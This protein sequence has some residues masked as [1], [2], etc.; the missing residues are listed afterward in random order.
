MERFLQYLTNKEVYLL[1]PTENS[2][3]LANKQS[4][5][6][7]SLPPGDRRTPPTPSAPSR[8]DFGGT[9]SQNRKAST[10]GQP[11]GRRLL[12]S[13]KVELLVG[14]REGRSGSAV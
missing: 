7:K 8:P 2:I 9:G 1:M 3:D 4:L 11:L 12:V 14:V 13:R 6:S 5:I 10:M